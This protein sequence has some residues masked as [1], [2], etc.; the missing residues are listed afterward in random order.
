MGENESCPGAA[1]QGGSLWSLWQEGLFL[2]LS[3][4]A[5]AWESECTVEWVFTRKHEIEGPTL[6]RCAFFFFFIINAQVI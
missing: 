2:R 3:M 6:P 1:A 4:T 5:R